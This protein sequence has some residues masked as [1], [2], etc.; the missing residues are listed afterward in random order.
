MGNLTRSQIKNGFKD[1]NSLV[2]FMNT[3]LGYRTTLVAYENPAQQLRIPP[4]LCTRING[5][6]LLCSYPGE[7]PFQV[8]FAEINGLTFYTC[9]DIVVSFLRSHPANYLFIFTEDYCYIVF[10]AVERS[11]EREQNTLR[12][13]P[14][15]YYRFS[16]IDCRNPVYNDLL[17]LDKLRLQHSTEDSVAIY[18]RVITALKLARPSNDTPE[19]FMRWYYRMGYSEETYDRLRES[20]LL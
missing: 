18:D 4:Y 20:G 10:F 14:K 19:W 1:R 8:H 2:Q 11:L 7:I 6:W 3:V 13:R 16:L 5:W 12:L 17:V 9:K 15:Y